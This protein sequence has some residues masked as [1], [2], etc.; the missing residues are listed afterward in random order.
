[1]DKVL[2]FIGPNSITIKDSLDPYFGTFIFMKYESSQ[3]I[4]FVKAIITEANLIIK[5][6]YK[7]DEPTIAFIAF[8]PTK[9]YLEKI[10]IIPFPVDENEEGII[11]IPDRIPYC[12]KIK[13][14]EIK[15][16]IKEV[17]ENEW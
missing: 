15:G 10:D 17:D 13:Y 16:E 9:K 7:I 6:N 14:V 8:S 4:K 11:P 12:G 1:M 2:P 3:D 5:N